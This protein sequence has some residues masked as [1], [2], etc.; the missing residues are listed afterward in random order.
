M[1]DAPAKSRKLAGN[2]FTKAKE[3]GLPPPASKN[4]HTKKAERRQKYNAKG[5]HED[6]IWMASGAEADRYLQLRKLQVDG[7]I[8]RL[9]CQPNFPLVVN[10][11]HVCHYRAD[12]RYVELDRE[13]GGPRRV[14]IEDV[15]GFR[16]DEFIL[17]SKL[18][19]AL[20]R[21]FDYYEIPATQV[22]KWD[23]LIPE[24]TK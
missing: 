18:F 19:A 6:G 3:L 9:E 13:R 20:Y 21:G 17:K 7:F 11:T 2:Q 14:I 1:N 12:F 4:Q 23:G 15:K 8:E 16:T 22:P 5:R 24:K 10:G